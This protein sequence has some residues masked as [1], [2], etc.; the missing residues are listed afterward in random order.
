LQGRVFSAESISKSLYET[1]LKL[2]KY[3]GLLAANRAE[4]RHVF[5][6]EF[7]NINTRLD[8]ILA[9]TLAQSEDHRVGG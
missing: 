3:R 2:A 5:H 4:A 8:E 9:I 6:Q 7:R 1:A